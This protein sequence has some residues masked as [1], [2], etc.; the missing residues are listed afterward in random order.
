MSAKENNVRSG[1]EEEVDVHTSYERQK[2]SMNGFSS[3]SEKSGRSQDMIN[4]KIINFW[5]KKVNRKNA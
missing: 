1:S 3:I 4:L 5:T 2:E